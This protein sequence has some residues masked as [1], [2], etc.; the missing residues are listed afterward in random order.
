MNGNHDG[1][2]E[3]N[4][5]MDVSG[6][7][8]IDNEERAMK[9]KRIRTEEDKCIR[10]K[11]NHPLLTSCKCRKLCIKNICEDRRKAIHS[12]YWTY[13]YKERKMFLY[14]RI[15]RLAVNRRTKDAKSIRKRDFSFKYHFQGDDGVDREVCQYF[16]IR[17]LG[18]KSH[19]VIQTVTTDSDLSSPPTSCF[20]YGFHS[21]RKCS[22]FGIE[23]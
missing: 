8:N 16:F 23:I 7:E 22:W 6:D 9:V 12:T 11:R 10:D 2:L 21:R 17:T 4:E 18:Y 20:F 15:S 13:N 3:T 19:R 14:S 5:E 1:I